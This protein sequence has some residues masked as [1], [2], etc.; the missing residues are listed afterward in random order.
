MGP[1]IVLQQIS[2]TSAQLTRIAVWQHAVPSRS[3]PARA[4][5]GR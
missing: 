3:D 4:V 2:K 1:N 5:A